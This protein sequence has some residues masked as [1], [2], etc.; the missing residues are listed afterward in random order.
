MSPPHRDHVWDVV[1]PKQPVAAEVEM[2]VT[3]R[4]GCYKDGSG[5]EGGLGVVVE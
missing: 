2:E 5:V 4:E 3:R 1:E